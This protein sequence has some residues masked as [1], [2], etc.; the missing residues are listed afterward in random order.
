PQPSR[1]P[2]ENARGGAPL[3]P[4]A[5]QI[6]S[7]CSSGFMGANS[8][9]GSMRSQGKLALTLALIAATLALGFGSVAHAQGAPIYVGPGGPPP[10]EPPGYIRAAPLPD[11]GLLPR[12]VVGILRSTGFSPLSPPF[13]RGRFYLVAVIDPN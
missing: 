9:E 3:G 8:G 10:F 1:L 11:D 12:E 5:A 6:A 13:R 4:S 2:P 7:D